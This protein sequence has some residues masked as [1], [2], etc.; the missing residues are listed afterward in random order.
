M[1]IVVHLEARRP[2]GVV[3]PRDAV[4]EFLEQP[5]R[6][7]RRNVEHLAELPELA[8]ALRARRYP[9]SELH[10]HVYMCM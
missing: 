6:V 7:G 4:A 8:A 1:C 9:E 5:R 2:L 3:A 10:V